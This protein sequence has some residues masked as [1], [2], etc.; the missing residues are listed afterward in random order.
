MRGVVMYAPG[1]VRV[2]ELED[3]KIAEPTDAV[4]RLANAWDE[5]RATKVL[6]TD[7][8]DPGRNG[9]WSGVHHRVIGKLSRLPE[10]SGTDLQTAGT[11]PAVA[12]AR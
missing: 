3:A 2:E 4:I 10:S 5:R 9:R 8:I 6:L 11:H 12:A 7:P 1:D